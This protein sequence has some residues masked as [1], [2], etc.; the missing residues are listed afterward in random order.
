MTETRRPNEFGDPLYQTLEWVLHSLENPAQAAADWVAQEVDPSRPTAA[1]LLADP[2]TPLSRIVRAR[3]YYMALRAEGESGAER[4][5]GGRMATAAAA[6]ALVHYGERITP[7]DDAALGTAFRA[8]EQDSAV[9][10]DLRELL[11]KAIA[12]LPVGF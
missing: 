7:H 8:A 11:R 9:P 4:T 3:S 10:N 6:A 12:A 2:Q 5:L 1:A